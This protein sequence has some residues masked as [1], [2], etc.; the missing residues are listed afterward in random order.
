MSLTVSRAG[1][2]GLPLSVAL[3]VTE[4]GDVVAA[5]APSS[6]T[7]PAVETGVTFEVATVDD[8]VEEDDSAV[9]VE[10]LSGAAYTV[11]AYRSA[12]VPVYDNDAPPTVAIQREFDANEGHPAR[13]IVSRAGSAAAAVTVQ[14]TITETGDMIDPDDEGSTSVVIPAGA[15]SATLE[16]PTVDDTVEEADSTVTATINAGAGYGIG[17]P[18]SAGVIV[19]DNDT[20][21]PTVTITP[22]TSPITEGYSAGFGISRTGPTFSQLTVYLT[23]AE[24]GDMIDEGPRAVTIRA[25]HSS[26]TLS[27]RTV[28]D[29][30]AE[31]NSTITATIDASTRYTIGT[32]KSATVTANDD[33]TTPTV[34]IRSTS[35]L[36]TEGDLVGITVHRSGPTTSPLTIQ[37]TISETGDMIAP[38]DEGSISFTIPAGQ[39]TAALSVATVDDTTDEDDSTIT[40]TISD[41]GGLTIG[42]PSM[43]SATIRDDDRP[44]S[45]V[46]IAPG[47]SPITEG[48]FAHFTITRT[49]PT[50]HRLTVAVTVA[51]TGEMVHV[52]DQGAQLVTIRAGQTSATLE[53]ATVDDTADEDDST[54]TATITR[55]PYST[56][57]TIG[58][59]N[60]ATITTND[61][62]SP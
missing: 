47:T 21:P 9:T 6:V 37:L 45:T 50:T 46:T 23:V 13:F 11:D 33:D 31:A 12:S 7:I 19:Y 43:R 2:L 51:E 49:D 60:S 14:L 48:A 10:I 55:D 61:N 8:A 62:D 18:A 1:P 30:A 58:T 41:G 16:I 38:D 22:G 39:I 28:D 3:R 32:P 56:R 24:T 27:V 59:P 34:T 54:I 29:T 57:Y 4:T 40:V 44:L 35:S 17:I 53:V 20:S 42:S 25:G 52:D 36:V 5:A 15:I 26:A